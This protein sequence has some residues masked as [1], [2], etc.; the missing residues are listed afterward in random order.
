MPFEDRGSALPADYQINGP[1][2]NASDPFASLNFSSYFN[3][4][5]AVATSVSL[6]GPQTDQTNGFLPGNTAL[7]YT[8]NFQNNPGTSSYVNQITIV[9]QLDPS[10]DPTTFQLG[11]I[12]IGGI[13]VSI[14]AGHT[15]FTQDIDFTSTLGFI[16]RISAGLDLSQNPAAV[17]W[18]IQAIDPLTGQPLT[19]ST[20]GLLMPNDAQGSGAGYVSWT[21][22][23]K[24]DVATGTM[25]SESAAI[26]YDTQP[27]QTTETLTQAV[28]EIAPTTTLSATQ[29]GTTN[30]YKV[31]YSV[32]DDEGGSGFAHV[33]LYVAT[34]GGNY[35]IWQSQLTAASGTLVYTG[36]AGHTYQFLGLATDNAGNQEQPISTTAQV[37]NDGSSVTLGTTPQV[38]TTAP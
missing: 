11:D 12:K 37:P 6:T 1:V 31:T 21:A 25:V 17:K 23:L 14:P 22:Q 34:D 19:D 35:V 26:L 4:A 36:S 20:R 16:L 30:A 38:T 5:G 9:T 2:P 28:D 10:L 24:P 32:T 33:T 8:I 7:P 13:T 15:N 27:P 29:I 3:N 18:V